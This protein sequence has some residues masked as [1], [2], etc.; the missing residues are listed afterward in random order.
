MFNAT[1]VVVL[2]YLPQINEYLQ[3]IHRMHPSL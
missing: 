2:Q 3:K 1:N